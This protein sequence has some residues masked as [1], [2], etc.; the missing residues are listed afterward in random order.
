MGQKRRRKDEVWVRWL[1]RPE[2]LPRCHRL[3]GAPVRRQT[4]QDRR[5]INGIELV[6]LLSLAEV[7]Q[8]NHQHQE[9]HQG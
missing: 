6:R 7:K 2:A 1:A 9:P 4:S 5:T 8:I 3:G